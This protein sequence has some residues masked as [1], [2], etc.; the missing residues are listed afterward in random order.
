[1]QIGSNT[2]VWFA[3]SSGVRE[4]TL[5]KAMAEHV[6]CFLTEAEAWEVVVRRL[7]L[8]VSRAE[9]ALEHATA[10]LAASRAKATPEG[11]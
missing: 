11:A 9:A 2:S 6:A 1:M 7:A 5:A 10:S 3:S 4:T 8:D